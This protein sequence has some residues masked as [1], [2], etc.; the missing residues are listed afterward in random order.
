MLSCM[1]FLVQ[2]L[3]NLP[4]DF[5]SKQQSPI[6]NLNLVQKNKAALEQPYSP[7]NNSV[8]KAIDFSVIP[9]RTSEILFPKDEKKL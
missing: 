9:D 8:M 6:I 3:L 2:A 4:V 5:S 1:A 7:V